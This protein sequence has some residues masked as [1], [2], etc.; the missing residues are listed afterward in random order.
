[1]EGAKKAQSKIDKP[2]SFSLLPAVASQACEVCFIPGMVLKTEPIAK[3]PGERKYDKFYYDADAFL[4]LLKYDHVNKSGL[5]KKL[6]A[7]I[8]M[9]ENGSSQ[10]G[11]GR[12]L[13]IY[14]QFIYKKIYLDLGPALILW[15]R[16]TIEQQYRRRK[17]Q[18]KNPDLAEWWL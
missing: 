10:K 5:D 3:H 1:M 7:L 15:L 12:Q 16:L 4:P 8:T 14:G 17:V 18:V 11:E 9:L 6:Q 13:M 2:V